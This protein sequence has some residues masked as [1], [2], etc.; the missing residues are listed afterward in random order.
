VK[1][2]SCKEPLG[3]VVLAHRP[4]EGEASLSLGPLGP[5]SNVAEAW[6]APDATRRPVLDLPWDRVS[7]TP[8]RSLVQCHA[9]ESA[10]AGPPRPPARR[11]GHGP[12]AR[13]ALAGD[14]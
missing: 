8:C 5:S 7:P 2:T 4:D 10:K 12:V 1:V 14:A 6:V 13:R 9:M 3:C 11:S